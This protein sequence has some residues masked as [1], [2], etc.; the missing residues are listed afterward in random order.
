MAV[1][2]SRVVEHRV[3]SFVVECGDI[4]STREAFEAKLRWLLL[5]S[6]CRSKNN[7]SRET[8]TLPSNTI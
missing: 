1:V 3:V 2:L 4:L 8:L 7:A 5:I 6:G